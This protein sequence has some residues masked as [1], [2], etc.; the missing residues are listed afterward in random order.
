MARI[1]LIICALFAVIQF[2]KPAQAT[3]PRYAS[4]LD[5]PFGVS[6]THLFLL[7]NV[8]DNEGSHYINASK[9][10]LIAQALASGRTEH[11]WPLEITR[12]TFVDVDARTFEYH[13][14]PPKY[15]VLDILSE[16]SAAPLNLS[17]ATDWI[18]D[19]LQIST[20]FVLSEAGILD[21]ATDQP[22][23]LATP[24]EIQTRVDAS[25]IPFME[26]LPDDP[27]PVDPI[28]FDGNAYTKDLADCI[29][30]KMW[31]NVLAHNIYRLECES[32][33]YEI[34]SY[35]LFLTIPKKD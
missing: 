35:Q 24:N 9:R 11:I 31:G 4:V 22:T 3:P 6:Q 14:V 28:T 1:L 29:V 7:R 30:L 12:E 20:R 2:T 10:F 13:R 33:E 8:S 5:T 21:Q 34:L 15:D 25:L 32:G 27:G 17:L 23:V 18:G 19:R 26:T 16:F